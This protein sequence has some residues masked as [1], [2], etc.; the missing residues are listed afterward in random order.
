MALGLRLSPRAH[1]P[2]PGGNLSTT[3]SYKS[4]GWDKVGLSA[5]LGEKAQP[6]CSGEVTR[7][8]PGPL[9][10]GVNES[11]I[12]CHPQPLADADTAFRRGE[13]ERVCSKASKAHFFQSGK[14]RSKRGKLRMRS[15]R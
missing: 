13:R 10:G 4:Q 5:A 9:L 1:E 2:T 12:W 11:S 7:G 6:V 14:I 3:G 15:R 8:D